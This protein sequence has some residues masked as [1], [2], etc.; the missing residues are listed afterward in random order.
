MAHANSE[1]YKKPDVIARM[2]KREVVS[3]VKIDPDPKNKK[4]RI[5]NMTA[6]GLVEG[7][8]TSR[9]LQFMADYENLQKVA[10]QYIKKSELL[11][12]REQGKLQKYLHMV[13]EVKAL[14]LTYELEVFARVHE[15]EGKD[16]AK[17]VWEIVPARSLKHTTK[18]IERFVGLKGTVG[19]EKYHMLRMPPALVN[20]TGRG[21]YRRQTEKERIMVL[22]KGELKKPDKDM[23]RLIPNFVLQFAME[24]ALQRVGILLR[25]YIETAKEVPSPKSLEKMVDA[26]LRNTPKPA[27]E[28]SREPRPPK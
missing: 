11:V 18:D 9:A 23:A 28:T 19:V 24:V 15:E 5:L 16:H 4:N 2:E 7:V 21:F 27:A 12:R 22:F 10:P 26:D 25:N 6:V 20:H 17:V 1:F 13:T 8:T 3:V 14:L